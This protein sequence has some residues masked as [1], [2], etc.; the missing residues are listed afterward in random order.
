ML[1]R[2]AIGVAGAA[3]FTEGLPPLLFFGGPAADTGGAAA[4]TGRALPVERDEVPALFPLRLPNERAA[5]AGR[6]DGRSN[7]NS[8]SGERSHDPAARA[9]PGR[10]A[11]STEVGS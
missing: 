11:S 10:R 3:D 8:R 1:E 7:D 6:G 9:P 5:E 4:T 2:I